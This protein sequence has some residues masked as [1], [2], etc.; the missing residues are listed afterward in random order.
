MKLFTL[1]MLAMF[2]SFASFA[3]V[4]I[5]PSSGGLCIGSTLYLTDSALLGTSPSGTW[6]SSNPS[7]AS[8]DTSG[9]LLGVSAGVVTV[10]FTYSSG[11]AYGTYTVSPSPANITGGPTRFCVGTAATFMDA[12]AGGVWSSTWNTTIDAATGVATGAY[13]GT[14]TIYYTVGACTVSISDTV[15][16][17]T[18]DYISGPT[19]VCVGSTITL[20]DSTGLSSGVWS[21]SDVSIA[22]ISS[23]GVVTGVS[24]GSVVIT[25]TFSG[26]CGSAYS[27]YD[28]TVGPLTGGYVAG[29]GSINIGATGA[30]YYYGSASGGV[31]SVTPPS[32]ATID[33][34]GTVTGVSAGLA[35]VTYS[36]TSCGS[37][38][39]ST[40]TVNITPLDGISGNVNF[41]SSYYGNVKVWLITYTPGTTT[42]AAYDSLTL[43]CS[44]SSVYY[45]FTGIP[46]DSFRVKAAT[47]DSSGSTTGFIP[48]YHTSSYYWHD[49]D[50]INHTSG[51][52]DIHE[53]INMMTGTSTSG[54]GF[55]SGNVLTG[56]N[57][58]TSGS[59]PVVGLHMVALNTS[60]STATVAQMTYTD[61]SGNYT[62]SNLPTGTYTVFPDSINFITTPYTNIVLTSGAPTY[63]TAAFTQHTIAKTITP[64]VESIKNLSAVASVVAFPNPTNGR[65]NIMWNEKATENASVV[66]SDITGREVYITTLTLTDG[67][68]ISP[69]DLSSLNNGLY[70]ISIKTATLNYDGKIEIRH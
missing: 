14:G 15:D 42:L 21:S 30:F 69:V 49:A 38:I 53:D 7:I 37:P 54:P 4:S 17:T 68:G 57:R 29:P 48:T 70:V 44:G 36:A 20:T 63:S 67:N 8:I 2:F 27:T 32:L 50:V 35:T 9:A 45:E 51:A 40:T 24:A 62:F 18:V 46:T 60:G 47:P 59:I 41:S 39:V 58:G 23:A 16:A 25:L 65:L 22:T 43:Y 56:A 5:T 33:A 64:G 52:S 11:A 55:I 10:T 66:I 3:Q 34:S 61:G 6:S 13:G 19:N 28:I 31:W 26:I 12:T 1:A